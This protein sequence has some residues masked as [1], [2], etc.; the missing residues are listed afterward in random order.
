M[1]EGSPISANGCIGEML[2]SIY[3]NS[4]QTEKKAETKRRVV[5]LYYQAQEHELP[6]LAAA[7]MPDSALL[8]RSSP[9]ISR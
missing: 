9:V 5:K 1:D 7:N 3:T 6:M 4:T 8:A 2:N